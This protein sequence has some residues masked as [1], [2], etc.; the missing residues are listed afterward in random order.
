MGRMR[1]VWG[2]LVAVG[3]TAICPALARADEIP[4]LFVAWEAPQDC[5]DRNAFVHLVAGHLAG[6]APAKAMHVEVQ[7]LPAAAGGKDLALTLRTRTE[8]ADGERVLHG[9]DCS[10]LADTAALTLA[11]AI[12]PDAVKSPA[13]GGSGGGGGGEDGPA[14]DD[15]VPPGQRQAPAE[16]TAAA[17]VTAPASG[18]SEW[19]VP[20]LLKLGMAGEDG[21]MPG[22]G[23]GV[24]GGVGVHGSR[25][26][27][28]VL[29]AY[30]FEKRAAAQVDPSEMADFSAAVI[31]LRM[32][33]DLFQH[34]VVDAGVCAGGEL[35][36]MKGVGSGDTA[37]HLW[38]QLPFGPSVAW[39]VTRVFWLRGDMEVV[40]R[41]ERPLF[42]DSER[43]GLVIYRPEWVGVRGGVALE[44]HFR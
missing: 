29:G 16:T 26:R 32:C 14:L 25:L 8:D 1:A 44:A 38:P 41:R 27:L 13:G 24:R 21:T 20:T 12:A 35:I 15:E 34:Q 2:T 5:P 30:W 3:L 23:T 17:T 9:K 10:V 39:K 42:T 4:R 36:R 18:G 33:A 22:F 7:V 43:T 11:L 28:E 37:T 19:G 31:T 6:Q 40:W